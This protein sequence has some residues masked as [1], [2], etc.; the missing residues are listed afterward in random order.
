VSTLRRERCRAF[1]VCSSV[2]RALL[3]VGEVLDMA[4]VVGSMEMGRAVNVSRGSMVGLI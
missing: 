2:W 4:L 1:R 3:A